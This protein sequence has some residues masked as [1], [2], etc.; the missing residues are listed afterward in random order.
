[1]AVNCIARAEKQYFWCPSDWF[2]ADE[3]VLNAV[4][5]AALGEMGNGTKWWLLPCLF[6]ICDFSFRFNCFS[7]NL[8]D[9]GNDHPGLLWSYVVACRCYHYRCRDARTEAL[10]RQ[11]T[12]WLSPFVTCCTRSVEM[13]PWNRVSPPLQYPCGGE[14]RGNCQ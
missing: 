1:M 13:L 5:Q 12:G 4:W 7:I 10:A 6:L 2:G 8:P 14:K 3:K 9:G 11:S